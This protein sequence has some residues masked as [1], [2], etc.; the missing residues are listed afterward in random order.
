MHRVRICNRRVHFQKTYSGTSFAPAR[1]F[2]PTAPD[3]R[4]GDWTWAVLRIAW[5]LRLL[6]PTIQIEDKRGGCTSWPPFRLRISVAAAPPGSLCPFWP[7]F[8]LRISKQLHLLAPIQVE[9]KRGGLH[10]LAPIQVE[11]KRG[12]CTSWP[13]CRLRMNVAAA[14]PGPHSG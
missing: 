3:D 13:P 12:G 9:D 8:K 14:L 1:V 4:S 6:T 2:H 11:D 10:L 5:R 7:L